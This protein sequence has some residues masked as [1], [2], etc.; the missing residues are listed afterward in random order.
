MKLWNQE[1]SHTFEE[2]ERWAHE[3][4]SISENETLEPRSITQSLKR[5]DQETS[6]IFET[7]NLD[8]KKHYTSLQLWSR[9][10]LNIFDKIELWSQETYRAPKAKGHFGP[11]NIKHLWN[12]GT[13]K[14]QQSLEN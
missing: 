9:Q 2:I 14:H 1:T 11:R 7:S 13:E 3:T 6:N 4:V 12:F 5:W 10:T 8:T